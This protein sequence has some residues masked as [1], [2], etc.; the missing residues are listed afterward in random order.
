MNQGI[1]ERNSMLNDEFNQDFIITQSYGPYFRI[2]FLDIKIFF[3]VFPHDQ[4]NYFAYMKAE[5]ITQGQFRLDSKNNFEC[6]QN[7]MSSCL[8][9]AYG[10]DSKQI[11]CTSVQLDKITAYICQ[12]V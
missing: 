6:L 1:D 2:Q 8:D 10:S 7:C 12:F 9:L 4:I 3:M 11:P 5:R